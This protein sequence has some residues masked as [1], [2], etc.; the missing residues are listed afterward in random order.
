MRKP[1]VAIIDYGLGNLFSVQLA[2]ASAGLRTVITACAHDILAAD[3]LILPGVGA[4]G[5]AM[6]AL[7][8]LRLVPVLQHAAA[9][10]KPLFGICLGMQLLMTESAEFGTHAGL[11]LIPGRVVRFERPLDTA[12]NVL[13]VPHI[14]WNRIYH[15]HDASPPGLLRDVPSGTYM[16]FVHSFYVEPVVPWVVWSRSQYGHIEFCASL[17]YQNIFACQFHPERSGRQGLRLYHN[18]AAQ[19]T[20]MDSET[21]ELSSRCLASAG[22]EKGSI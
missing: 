9:S 3:A 10:G 18:L 12:G 21:A 1:L 4:F 7:E 14:G 6:R 16:Y 5:D 8:E 22:T 15:P 2:C 19:F 13:K 11:G 20:G 17:Q